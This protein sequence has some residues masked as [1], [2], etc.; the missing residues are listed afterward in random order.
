MSDERDDPHATL[1][2]EI[3][4]A[5]ARQKDQVE[6]AVA[7]LPDAAWPVRLGDDGNSVSVLV[8]HLSGNLASRWRDPFTSDGEKPDRDRDGEFDDRELEPAAIM[9]AWQE[10][11]GI[12]LGTIGAL[13]PEDLA[14]T[15][16]I[17]D[18]PLSV[19][20]ALVRSLDHTGHHVGQIVML[21]KH[22]C[23]PDWATMSLPRRPRPDA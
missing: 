3:Q 23:G 11:W 13:R 16:T 10:A 6:R 9:D 22:L 8:R 20:A 17:R 1:L 14:R 7:Q 5:F 21:A 19:A 2:R 18:Q 4:A 15:I 12:A